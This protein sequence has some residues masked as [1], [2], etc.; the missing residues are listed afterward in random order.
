MSVI[1]LVI[2]AVAGLFLGDHVWPRK[3]NAGSEPCSTIVLETYSPVRQLATG[4]TANLRKYSDG[5]LAFMGCPTIQCAQGSCTAV[6]SATTIHCE[7]G[8]SADPMY[9]CLSVVTQDK[10]TGEV[11]GYVCIQQICSNECD[12]VIP[13][14][15]PAG[16]PPID[17]AACDC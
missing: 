16:H 14:P 6:E 10:D 9:L 7:C 4:C 11:T 15:P 1:V 5:T 13:A 3:P 8:D 2:V 17:F 12:T